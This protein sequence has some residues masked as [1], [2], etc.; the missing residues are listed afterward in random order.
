MER[1][2]FV[3]RHFNIVL[4]KHDKMEKEEANTFIW[5]WAQQP[6]RRKTVSG[7]GHKSQRPT[8]SHSQ[9]FHKNPKLIAVLYR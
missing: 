8:R 2:R 1:W 9:E 3:K 6:N 4:K 7:A 5:S